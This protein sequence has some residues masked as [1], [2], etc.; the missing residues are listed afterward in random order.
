MNLKMVKYITGRLLLV[1][2][3]L[4]LLPLIV[5]LIYGEFGMLKTVIVPILIA[6]AIGFL[7]SAKKPLDKTLHAKDGFVI[8]GLSWIVVSLVGC[9][10][11][12]MSGLIPNFIDAFFETV[13]GF[14]TTGASVLGS[15]DFDKLWMPESSLNGM[16]GIFFWRSL[17]NWIGG[18]GVLVFVLAI[19]PQQDMKSSR[20]VHLM[21][22]EMPGPK[23]DKIVSTVKKTSAIMYTIYIALTLLQ[24]TLL[25]F[26]GMNLYEALCTA[27]STGGTGGF[28]IWPDSMATFTGSAVHSPNYCVW[29]ITVFMYIFSINFNLYYLLIT[30]KALAALLSEELWWFIGIVVVSISAITINIFTTYQ[31]L[32]LSIR[33]AAFQVATVISTTG[34][35]TTDFNA[36]PNFSKTLML[37]LMF[38]G[39]CAGSTGG[40]IKI[41]RLVIMIK[42]ALAEIGHMIRPRQ[43]KKITFERK[44]IGD[45]TV[46]GTYAYIVAYVVVFFASFLLVSAFDGQSIETSFSAIVACINNIGPGFDQVG[47]TSNYAF[48]SPMS[49]IVLA[50]D[51]LLGRLE[52]FPILL[53]FS[54]SVWLEK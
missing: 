29:V 49:K 4:L 27:M 35:A 31:S 48:L 21:R 25:L 16:R 45:D 38:I 11:F 2:G 18:M 24:V 41:S 20:L 44:S 28:A 39:A 54:P 10:P 19:M 8:V 32:S 5:M 12:M 14:T 53:L 7:L 9:I 50:F 15:A 33:D 47:A 30:G 40:G 3:A 17:T 23:V 52:I 1:E 34:F 46:K 51:M 42:G 37:T 26:G 13:S 43:V 6:L 22:A 36:W